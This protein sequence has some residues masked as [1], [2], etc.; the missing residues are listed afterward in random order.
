MDRIWYWLWIRSD[1]LR[2]SI[3]REITSDNNQRDENDREKTSQ[4]NGMIGSDQMG[5]KPIMCCLSD[6]VCVWGGGEV[7]L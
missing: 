5:G 2:W 3:A 6:C 7:L 1:L 4:W